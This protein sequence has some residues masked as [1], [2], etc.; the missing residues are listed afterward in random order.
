[1]T[2]NAHLKKLITSLTSSIRVI[3]ATAYTSWGWRCSTLKIAFD[4]LVG[5]KLDYAAPAW[6]PWLSTTNLSN[7]DCFQNH[8]LQLITGQLVSTPLEALRLE[9]DV[10]SYST[11]SK[12][13]ILRAYEKAQRSADDHPKRIA[14]DVNIPQCLQSRSSFRRKVEELST[15]LPLDLQ[16][17]QNIIHFPSPPWQQSSSHTGKISTT[18]PGITSRAD[19]NETRQKCSLSTIISYQA[20]CIVY[21]V[22]SVSG[23]RR[24]GGVAEVATRRS[25]LQPDVVTLIKTKGHTLL[26]PM[27]KKQLP[28]NLH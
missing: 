23:G 27:R 5:S 14:L 21:T 10:Q 3:R 11:C 4:A 8:Y 22:G 24:N 6:Q 17:R 28:W 16:H 15:L 7:L 19:D 12:L 18:V 26:A 25:P 2:F 9:A 20:D 1:M 13:L